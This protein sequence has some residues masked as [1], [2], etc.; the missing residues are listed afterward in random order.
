MGWKPGGVV[1]IAAGPGNR[2]DYILGVPPYD[3]GQPP[4][5]IITLGASAALVNELRQRVASDGYKL[6]EL[7]AP[8]AET[9]AAALQVAGQAGF[10]DIV[11]LGADVALYELLEP[12]ANKGCII[13]IVGAQALEGKAQVDVG[14]LHYDNLSLTGTGGNMIAMAYEPIRT[15]LKPGGTAAFIGAA[16]PM[17][18]MHVQRVWNPPN[19]PGWPL[20]PT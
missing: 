11:L 7:G 2:D 15:E 17:G 5:Q 6:T 16:G 13:N 12:V 1:V 9:L 8:T 14:R 10:D 19:R 18:Q 3:G 4:A 20:P